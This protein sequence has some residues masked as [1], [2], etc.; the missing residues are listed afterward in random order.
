MRELRRLGARRQIVWTLT[1]TQVLH[2]EGE[3]VKTLQLQICNSFPLTFSIQAFCLS[4]LH[5]F[6]FTRHVILYLLKTFLCSFFFQQRAFYLDP[7]FSRTQ[8][9][10][11]RVTPLLITLLD[12]RWNAVLY[13]R[14][15]WGSMPHLLLEQ[16]LEVFPE[17]LLEMVTS[18]LLPPF[19]LWV[20]TKNIRLKKTDQG[21]TSIMRSHVWP[22]KSLLEIH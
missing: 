1:H 2:R 5:G 7:S 3:M 22:G 9:Q 11:Q 8:F 12:L 15:R 14:Q 10:T 13:K 6:P 17:T 20:T 19:S 16:R 4:F 21:N 18:G